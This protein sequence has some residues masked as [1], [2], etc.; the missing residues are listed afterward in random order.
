MMTTLWCSI[1][2]V[3]STRRPITEPQT[4]GLG[5][6][7]VEKAPPA[8]SANELALGFVLRKRIVWISGIDKTSGADRQKCF[9]L[10]DGFSNY[11]VWLAGVKLGL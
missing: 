9:H 6:L 5:F 4:I 11:V 3:P 10:I 7:Q 2:T 8:L 1:E